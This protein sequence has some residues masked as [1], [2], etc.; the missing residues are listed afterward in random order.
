[1]V[2]SNNVVKSCLLFCFFQIIL[3]SYQLYGMESDGIRPVKYDSTIRGAKERYALGTSQILDI[4]DGH[5]IPDI[6]APYRCLRELLAIPGDQARGLRGQAAHKLGLMCRAHLAVP[7]VENGVK[8]AQRYFSIAAY[9][10]HSPS[11]GEL[12]RCACDR[13]DYAEAINC[14][15]HERF[16]EISQNCLA[17]AG[18][19]V[20]SVLDNVSYALD[21]ESLL[22]VNIKKQPSYKVAINSFVHAL[23]PLAFHGNG[24]ASCLLARLYANISDNAHAV[25]VLRPVLNTYTCREICDLISSTK[26]HE[27]LRLVVQSCVVDK[28]D[29]KVRLILGLIKYKKPEDDALA[30]EYLYQCAKNNNPYACYSCAQMLSEGR[31]TERSLDGAARMYARALSS[32]SIDDTMRSGCIDALRKIACLGSIIGRCELIIASLHDSVPLQELKSY[33]DAVFEKPKKEWVEYI[34]YL[35]SPR[36]N[37]LLMKAK[38]E[39]NERALFILGKLLSV[40]AGVC[41]T[42]IDKKIQLLQSSFDLL[43]KVHDQKIV[44]TVDLGNI[45][46]LLGDAY[47]DKG[48]SDK[49]KE[50]LGYAAR[51]G[52]NDAKSA[53]AQLLLFQDKK[54]SSQQDIDMALEMFQE[55]AL[56]GNVEHQRLLAQLYRYDSTLEGSSA[57]IK[58]DVSKSYAFA[59]L[60]LD[61]K[62]DDIN[63]R[64]IMGTLLGTCG[65]QGVIPAQQEARAYEFLASVIDQVKDARPIDYYLLGRLC[66]A[67]GDYAQAMSWFCRA[68]DFPNCICYRGLIMLVEALN[69]NTQYDKNQAFDC[70]EKALCAARKYV[71]LHQVGF[72]ELFCHE[73]LIH[74][75]KQAADSGDLRARVMLAR[76]VFLFNDEMLGV[77]KQTALSYLIEAAKCGVASAE[78]YLGF[79][80]YRAHGVVRSDAK[81]LEYFIKASHERYVPD[82][83]L[84]EI[85]EELSAMAEESAVSPTTVT[86]AYYAIPALLRVFTPATLNRAIY[87]MNKAEGVLAGGFVDNKIMVR[88]AYDS[89]AWAAI[90]KIADEGSGDAAAVLGLSL[91]L[92][93]VKDIADFNKVK[94][95]GLPLLEQ[96]LEHGTTIL[97]P[98]LVSARYGQCLAHAFKNNLCSPLELRVLLERALQLDPANHDIAFIISTF[99]RQGIFHDI[100]SKEGVARG[101]AMLEELANKGYQYAALEAGL[102]NFSEH[103]QNGSRSSYLKAMQYLKIAGKQGNHYALLVLVTTL[104]RSTTAYSKHLNE[105]I[106]AI[107]DGFIAKNETVDSEKLMM[108]G[109]KYIAIHQMDKAIK[110]FEKLES[111]YSSFEDL[112][113]IAIIWF[114]LK[115]PKKALIMLLRVIDIARSQHID[116][117]GTSMAFM[118]KVILNELDKKAITDSRAAD[119]V[120]C[121]RAKLHEYNYIV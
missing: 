114:Y 20:E 22:P 86:A 12:A 10:G 61:Q 4:L 52:N 100:E 19:T 40:Q 58:A 104:S 68:G 34:K 18:C 106:I 1:M 85:A 96:A 27:A 109:I 17:Q 67:K 38:K 9:N 60:L 11:V 95:E 55:G 82:F 80:Y 83:I 105:E 42:K 25:D 49:A 30:F 87:L 64:Y 7:E 33:I 119:L 102:I 115:D 81:A 8:S 13:G 79:M 21:L 50:Y 51:G 92:R 103:M 28:N 121:L 56:Q 72:C 24:R 77:S 46:L 65:G 110:C 16:L 108:L 45:A 6:S 26:A 76:I 63:G 37:K 118:L 71:L 93:F 44:S 97:S 84:D 14:W 70:I 94:T 74:T 91:V 2:D 31:G 116:I 66:F 53:L 32:A 101:R 75:L 36:C 39:N 48:V 41:S 98:S 15:R 57:T 47:K 62:P 112:S 5:D 89:G 35:Q 43:R 111:T 117:Q 88:L 107:I 23:E 120:A 3:P 90:K 73:L 69:G 29:D 113:E 54:S 99:Y 78:S 59:K